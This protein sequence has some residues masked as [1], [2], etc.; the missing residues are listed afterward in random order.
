MAAVL[1]EEEKVRVRHHCGYLNVQAVATFV[2]GVPAAVE[3]QFMIEG[4]MDRVLP[5]AVPQV[6]RHLE[7]LDSIETQM[8][9]NHEL[10]QVKALGEIEVNS[11]GRDRE[12]VQLRQTY[13]YWVNSLCNLIGVVRNPFDKRKGAF[14]GGLNARVQ[15]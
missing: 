9:E 3:T 5:A 12:Q 13:D 8:V 2:L 4:A 14:G 10:L 15:H 11:T 1:T 6:V 7:I